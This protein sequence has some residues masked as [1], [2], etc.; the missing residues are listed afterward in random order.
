MLVVSVF[1]LWWVSD[2][3][4]R[5]SPGLQKVVHRYLGRSMDKSKTVTM[6]NWNA[7]PLTPRQLQY[8]AIDAVI[9]RDLALC[10]C[11]EKLEEFWSVSSLLM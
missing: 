3:R 7:W 2:H 5:Y 8:A 9:L 10:M 4:L 6:S 11:R 1:F